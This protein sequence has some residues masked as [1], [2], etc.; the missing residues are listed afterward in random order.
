MPANENTTSYYEATAAEYDRLH[1]EQNAEHTRA[2]ELLV[3]RYF[4][5]ASRILDVGTGTGRAL[6]WMATHFGAQGRTVDL[7][8][9]EPSAE[10]ARIARTKVPAATIVQGSG[11]AL[12]FEDASFDLVTITGVLHHVERPKAVL[13]EM[14][15]VSRHGVLISDHN[16]FAFGSDVARRLRLGLY[17]ANLLSAFSFVKQGFKRQGYS[18]DDGWWYPY[19]LLND[20]DVIAGKCDHFAVVPTRKANSRQGNFLL[21]NSHIAVACI[22][23]VA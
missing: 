7:T 14:F 4:A 5:S 17:A 12:P 8:G 20:F 16:N 1:G 6:A 21:S 19:S 18:K 23:K 3:P 9:V 2:L 15:R 13:A 10:L 22:K 11:D